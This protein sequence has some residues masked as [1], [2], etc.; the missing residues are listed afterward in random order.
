MLY[1]KMEDIIYCVVIMSAVCMCYE[2]VMSSDKV[3]LPFLPGIARFRMCY[4]WVMN[5]L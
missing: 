5:M 3:F 2:Y 1:T 4:E